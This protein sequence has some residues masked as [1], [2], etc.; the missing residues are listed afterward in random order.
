MLDIIGFLTTILGFIV[1]FITVWQ[2]A[3]DSPMDSG[4]RLLF[5]VLGLGSIGYFTMINLL[6]QLY[7]FPGF[8]IQESLLLAG[9]AFM[10]VNLGRS[11]M[12]PKILRIASRDLKSRGRC[13]VQMVIPE[14]FAICTI[15]TFTLGFFSM[16]NGLPEDIFNTA[17]FYMA[18]GVIIGSFLTGFITKGITTNLKLTLEK[19]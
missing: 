13:I 1:Y 5:A 17:V 3:R 2:V 12:A 18:P 15:L 14:S 8:S 9:L 4:V 19:N 10:S 11:I 16:D 6:P 7:E